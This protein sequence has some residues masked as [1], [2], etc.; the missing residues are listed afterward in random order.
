MQEKPK[1]PEPTNNLAE[2]GDL[3]NGEKR[4]N[5]R[6]TRGISKSIV[7]EYSRIRGRLRYLLNRMSYEQNLIDAYSGEGWKG[8]SLQK[9]K[10]EKELERAKSEIFCCKLKIRG[11]F[12]HLDSLI[13]EGRLPESLFDSEGQINSED[14]FC[15]KCGSKDLPADNDIILCDG[16]CERG[17][18]QFCLEPPL[19]KE[20]IPPDDQGWLCPGCH[21]K[22]DSIYLLNGFLGTNLS[23]LDTWEHVFPEA[24]S[25][26]AAGNR[27]DDSLEVAS[28]D[29]DDQD[30]EPDGS[31]EDEKAEGNKL[32]SNE[33]NYHSA[34]EDYAD[35]TNI[36]QNLELPCDDPKQDDYNPNAPGLEIKQEIPSHENRPSHTGESG[37]TAALAASLQARLHRSEPAQTS[38]WREILALGCPF[39]FSSSSDCT[40]DSGDTS[41]ASDERNSS[42]KDDIMPALSNQSKPCKGSDGEMS[43]VLWRRMQSSI[44]EQLSLLESEP[45]GLGN[46]A[47]A[48][49]QMHVETLDYEKLY[50]KT[51][52]NA[53][54]G[55][56]HKDWIEVDDSTKN[57]SS[58]NSKK[59]CSESLGGRTP[60]VEETD[61]EENHEESVRVHKRRACKKL[62]IEGTDTLPAKLP[63]SSSEADCCRSR[64]KRS[65]SERLGEAAIQE[66][67]KSFKENQYPERATKEKLARQLGITVLQVGRWFQN[68]R[69]RSGHSPQMESSVDESVLNSE[70]RTQSE[71]VA[72]DKVK[73]N[74]LNKGNAGVIIG[75]SSTEESNRQGS[76]DARGRKRKSQLDPQL[77]SKISGIE[78]MMTLSSLVGLSKAR[79]GLKRGRP[80]K[81]KE[82]NKVKCQPDHQQSDQILTIEETLNAVIDSAKAQ[83]RRRSGRCK[84]RKT[85]S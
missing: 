71:D 62:D 32:S 56:S 29:S 67:T 16:A 9:I 20:D 30:Y 55:S 40:S 81:N 34:S 76:R 22:I 41:V 61:V 84:S 39:F 51:H 8:Q 82:T 78:E 36:R 53:S 15:A 85:A 60:V 1:A 33:S 73:V 21:C 42:R 58:N 80:R 10:P 38:Q 45:A 11:L 77:S 3:T 83:D 31:E 37:S 35:S 19:L 14:I 66:L 48:A 6:K 52:V 72:K 49:E 64:A 17:F 68:A 65:A 28:E 4:R 54:R 27:L 5:T 63:G 79:Q 46:S 25:A 69:R 47:P 24:A 59:Y 44:N 57:R 7:D 2:H 26:A 18:H 74:E 13:A 75:M 12:Q 23:S 50:D 43:N 70:P